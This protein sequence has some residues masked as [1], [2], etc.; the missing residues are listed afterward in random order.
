MAHALTFLWGVLSVMLLAIIIPDTT[1]RSEIVYGVN[2]CKENGGLQSISNYNITQY[3]FRCVSGAVFQ[4][5][6]G[7]IN[8]FTQE[9]GKPNANY[10][11][12]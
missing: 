1:Y 7:D 6:G 11:I 12:K 9:Q 10:N 2:I 4:A 8:T 5:S 3:D